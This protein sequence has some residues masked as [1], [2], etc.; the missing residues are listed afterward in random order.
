MSFTHCTIILRVSA[1]S[2]LHNRWRLF[3]VMDHETSY[4]T[5]LCQ[6]TGNTLTTSVLS[7]DAKKK[8]NRRRLLLETPQLIGSVGE[9]EEVGKRASCRKVLGLEA[10]YL[11]TFLLDLTTWAN[12]T[13][14]DLT[15]A[16]FATNAVRSGRCRALRRVISD[17]RTVVQ[18]VSLNMSQRKNV[19]Q[20]M[21]KSGSDQENAQLPVDHLALVSD[22]S[23]RNDAMSVPHT[24]SLASIEHQVS[25]EADEP[26]NEVDFHDQSVITSLA[27]DSH[28]AAPE[29]TRP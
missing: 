21:V 11:E 26:T 28:K 25:A 10:L 14:P 7:E 19:S 17:R 1:G 6:S 18:R 29:Q 9:A 22:V 27:A 2:S 3:S 24:E 20:G 15:I 8:S 13:E 5:S 12:R 4:R 23:M 16:Q